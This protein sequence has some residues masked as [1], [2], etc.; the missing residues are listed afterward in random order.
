MTTSSNS[1]LTW[2]SDL[3]SFLKGR[4]KIQ[5]LAELTAVQ[6]LKAKSL[7]NQRN[8]EAE[9]AHVRRQV[10]GEASG[11]SAIAEQGDEMGTTILGDIHQQPPAVIMPQQSNSL[12]PVVALALAGLLPVAGIG[13]IGAG[14]ALAY[15]LQQPAAVV[16]KAA[17]PAEFEDTSTTI[18]LG[19]L[20][21]YGLE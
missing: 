5:Q 3:V 9:S 10:W 2:K 7:E 12:W 11:S 15:F 4:G 17:E 18:K 19:R 14:V 1:T 21:D 16:P 8:S 6:D 13:A 20:R